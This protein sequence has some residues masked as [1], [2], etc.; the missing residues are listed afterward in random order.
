MRCVQ[1][2]H[3]RIEFVPVCT[4]PHP[5][6]MPPSDECEEIVDNTKRHTHQS[7]PVL[8]VS[9]HRSRDYENARCP[10]PCIHAR[11]ISYLACEDIATDAARFRVAGSCL[12]ASPAFCHSRISVVEVRAANHTALRKEWDRLAYVFVGRNFASDCG[13]ARQWETRRLII[14]GL[15]MDRVFLTI[16]LE[17]GMFQ[18]LVAKASTPSRLLTSPRCKL[19][20]FNISMLTICRSCMSLGLAL[21]CRIL[22]VGNVTSEARC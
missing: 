4:L 6:F 19:R 3:C 9:H 5:R 18:T 2:R 13:S 12:L 14:S 11:P 20:H 7:A 16:A 15:S 22:R 8:R 17:L 10:S 21:G 1:A